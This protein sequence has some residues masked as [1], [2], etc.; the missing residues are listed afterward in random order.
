MILRHLMTAPAQGQKPSCTNCL[1]SSCPSSFLLLW[2]EHLRSESTST[3]VTHSLVL[4]HFSL[5]PPCSHV[6]SLHLTEA[7]IRFF[8]RHLQSTDLHGYD[9]IS[10]STESLFQTKGTNNALSRQV[11]TS[12]WKTCL[13]SQHNLRPLNTY[14]FIDF[15]ASVIMPKCP[16]QYI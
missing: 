8:A 15:F 10:R 14:I 3:H 5:L 4:Q 1:L 16:S 12:L 7:K 13:S 9:I 6:Q 2:K 11:F